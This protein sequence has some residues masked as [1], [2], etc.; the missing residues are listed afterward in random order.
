MKKLSLFMM[1]AALTGLFELAAAQ[2]SSTNV[3]HS[4]IVAAK[5]DTIPVDTLPSKKNKKNKKNLPNPNPEPNPN[6]PMPNPNPQ[7]NPNPPN[8][9]PNPTQPNNPTNPVPPGHVK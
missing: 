9:N 1:A 6:P 7:P 3:N 5:N 2:N 8:P 4:A